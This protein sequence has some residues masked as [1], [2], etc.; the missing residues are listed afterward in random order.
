LQG[1]KFEKESDTVN[2]HKQ[3]RPLYQ[4]HCLGFCQQVISFIQ[5]KGEYRYIEDWPEKPV[6]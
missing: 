5:Q 2:E 6:Y 4:L 3:A 1:A